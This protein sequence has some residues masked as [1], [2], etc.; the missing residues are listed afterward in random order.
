MKTMWQTWKY[1][2]PAF[3]V[4][5]AFVLTDNGSALLL[6]QDFVTVLWVTLVSAL[7][8][9]AL[10][11]VTSGWLVGPARWPERALCV[12]AALLLLYLQPLSIAIGIGFAVVAVVVHLLGRKTTPREQEPDD[13][14]PEDRGRDAEPAAGDGGMR[15]EADEQ[16]G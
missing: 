9:A 1:T 2:L 14:T 6:Q 5:I 15:R 13:A 16:H 12:P 8:V 3:L 4:P 10:A 11:V 7:G